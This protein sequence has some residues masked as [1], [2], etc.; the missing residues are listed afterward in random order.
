MSKIEEAIEKL[1]DAQNYLSES[2]LRDSR[3]FAEIAWGISEALS[4]LRDL[5][6]GVWLSREDAEQIKSQLEVFANVL[7]LTGNGPAAFLVRSCIK[8]LA[9]KEQDK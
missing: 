1:V 5:E 4:L 9:G 7:V 3:D 6:G 2:S 8:V